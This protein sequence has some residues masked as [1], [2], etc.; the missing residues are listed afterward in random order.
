M[1]EIFPLHLFP[2][3]AL[4]SSIITTV[5]LGIFVVAFFNL[6]LGWVL[7]GLVVPGYLV[8]L[9]LLKPSA[10]LIVFVEGS[11]TYLLVWFYSEFL[12]RH[13]G[14]SNFFGRDRF[15]AL[16]LTSVIVRIVGDGWL[17]PMLGEYIN[18]RWQLQF[19]YHNNLHS[20]GLIIVSLIANNFWKTGFRQ[21]LTP[22]FV[23]VG[24]TYLL[25]RYGLMELTN[26]SISDIGFLYEDVAT[27]ILASPKAYI[28]LL[29]TAFVASRMNLFYG[30]D[31]SGILIPSLIALQWYQPEK[32][33]FSFV[34]ALVVLFLAKLV[35]LA[36]FFQ[37]VTIE[38][39]RKLL[40]FFNVSF[41]YKM[42]LAYVLL[43]RWPELKVSDYYGFGY[44]LPTLMAIKMHDKDIIARLTRATL[45]TSIVAALV[46]TCIGF[47]LSLLPDP[48]GWL[49]ADARKQA[50]VH[51]ASHAG[52]L[53]DYL[54]EDKIFLYRTRTREQVGQPL[55]GELEA[56]VSASRWLAGVNRL[57]SDAELDQVASLLA[58]ANYQ[59]EIKEG[60]YLL[61]RENEPRLYR[62]TFVINPAAHSDLVVEVPAPLD[63][64]GALEA[65]AWIFRQYDARALVIAGSARRAN[66]DGSADVLLSPNTFF[67]AFHR[68][69]ARNS[70]LQVRTYTPETARVLA[71]SRRESGALEIAE[72]PSAV[73]VK[74]VLP[75]AFSLQALKLAIDHFDIVW[76]PTP[77]PNLQRDT[78][79]SGFVELLL[80][81]DDVRKVLARGLN[82]ERNT[83]LELLDRSME[84]YLQAWLLADKKRIAPA[85]SNLYQPPLLEQ[86]LYFDDEVLSP[87][88]AAMQRHYGEAGWTAAGLEELRLI[89]LAA[90]VVGYELV[91][92]RHQSTGRDYVILAE[93]EG[94]SARPYWGTYVFRPGVYQP[95][96]IEVPRPLVEVNS[97]E[98]AVAQ[99]ER[100]QGFA[101]LIGGAHPEAN[102]DHSADLVKLQNRA[103][104]F[105]LVGQV[106][107]R[108]SGD[109]AMLTLQSRVLGSRRESPLPASDLL[110]SFA[111][112]QV[113][114]D[115]LS[116]LGEQLL[117]SLEASGLSHKFAGGSVDAAGYDAAGVLQ[118]QHLGASRNKEF[119]IAWVSPL[120][121]NEYRQQSEPTP[122]AMHFAALHIPGQE[123]DLARLLGA[124]PFRPEPIPAD[125]QARID[126]YLLRQDIVLLHD[127][128]RAYGHFRFERIV[129]I[130]SRQGYLLI[131]DAQGRWLAVAN[132]SARQNTRLQ[133]VDRRNQDLRRQAGDFIERG[134]AWL[135]VERAQ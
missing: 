53:L 81:R 74:G 32:V 35:L 68:V 40:L 129:D 6:R 100:L 107:Q 8:P 66:K 128:L 63:E 72:P 13:F 39:A 48:W 127:A 77:L 111:D 26:F 10:A 27:S 102:F 103:S 91:R 95:Y 115:K 123:T 73:R 122:Q 93:I 130:N 64:H 88:L 46:A 17:L 99:F 37:R 118:A 134:S 30:W 117:Q 75:E 38:G 120:A 90:G 83:R 58:G 59:L 109:Q 2:E 4:A 101:L 78:T 61:L 29:T 19:D 125:L 16:V 22:L 54:R 51:P 85:G 41:A 14:W 124:R 62:G 98:F 104:V 86:L 121:R 131:S 49:V 25:I 97:F 96:V 5:W 42:V 110:I 11:L 119:A 106:I 18:Q 114:R 1:P 20:F 79:A 33:L 56:F 12:S 108:H 23:T 44:V 105:N 60:R 21:G 3:G 112:G 57:P 28:I 82:A 80:N 70:V 55:A 43:W 92:Y 69:F 87:L 24:I 76:Q 126:A 89:N 94:A 36:P 34:E 65:A 84:G 113:E 71:G 47:L 50:V 52:S 9:L 135:L 31:F 133:H 116:G 45:Q 15:F 7:S 132:L 67:Q